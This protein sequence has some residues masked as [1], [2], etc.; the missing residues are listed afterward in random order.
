MSKASLQK[1]NIGQKVFTHINLGENCLY[2]VNE[3]LNIYLGRSSV[4]VSLPE[5]HWQVF[6]AACPRE[7]Q[8]P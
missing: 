4:S 7:S 5:P 2:S 3:D 1:H 6:L 8:D